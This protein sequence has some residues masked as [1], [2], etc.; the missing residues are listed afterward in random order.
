MDITLSMEEYKNLM[1]QNIKMQIVVDSL[2]KNDREWE[3]V[4]M[5]RSLF[6]VPEVTKEA[7]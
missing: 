2:R 4:S 6:N 7:Q 3:T 5:L 1:E